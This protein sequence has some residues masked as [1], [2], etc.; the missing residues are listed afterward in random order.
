METI[1]QRFSTWKLVYL[2]NE[3]APADMDGQRL[4]VYGKEL[5]LIP[6]GSIFCACLVTDFLDILKWIPRRYGSDLDGVVI[7]ASGMANPNVIA[8]MLRE[9]QLDDVYELAQVISVVDPGTFSTLCQTLPNILEQVKAA[10]LILL[11]KC[12]LHSEE[13]V[14]PLQKTLQ[15]LNPQATVHQSRFGSLPEDWRLTGHSGAWELEGEYALCRDPNYR[16]FIASFQSAVGMDTLL[17]QLGA[18]EEELYRVK[19]FVPTPS[20]VQ[21]LEYAGGRWESAA[22]RNAP[23]TP[24]WELVFI[25]RGEAYAKTEAWIDG[26]NAA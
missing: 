5:V 10:D 12:D 26:Q 13:T 22:A 23:E 7:E 25:A 11:N 18:F 16:A 8:R 21:Y 14:V 3:F 9:T 20:G 1:I 4:S 6:G 2:V 19:G 15:T 24:P 17:E